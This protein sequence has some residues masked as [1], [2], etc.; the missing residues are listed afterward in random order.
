MKPKEIAAAGLLGGLVHAIVA[1]GL[2]NYFFGGGLFGLDDPS[3]TLFSVYVI[4]GALLLGAVPAVLFVHRRLV[5][6][7]VTVGTIALVALLSSS[8]GPESARAAGPSNF[9]FYFIWWLAPLAIALVVGG[10]EHLLRSR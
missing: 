1:G 8:P 2:H 7:G 9:A 4:C 5:T 10:V 3:I 6:P